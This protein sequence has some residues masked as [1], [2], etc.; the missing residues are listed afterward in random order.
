MKFIKS[1]AH[2]NEIVYSVDIY[3]RTTA[4]SSFLN[5]IENRRCNV[6]VASTIQLELHRSV[7]ILGSIAAKLNAFWCIC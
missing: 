2:A 7:R 6:T 1:D 3:P 4:S 5:K